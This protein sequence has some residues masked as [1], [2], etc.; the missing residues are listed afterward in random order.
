TT[1]SGVTFDACFARRARV[2][3]DGLRVNLISLND[4]KRNEAA[5]GRAKELDDLQALEESSNANF[6]TC[7]SDK[8]CPFSPV[9]RSRSISAWSGSKMVAR[10]PAHHQRLPQLPRGWRRGVAFSPPDHLPAGRPVA[11]PGLAAG[12]PLITRYVAVSSACVCLFTLAGCAN[13]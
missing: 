3:L 1:I 8:A 4:L 6:G 7:Q 10:V 5:S 11:G 13:F 2:K 12:L 9:C